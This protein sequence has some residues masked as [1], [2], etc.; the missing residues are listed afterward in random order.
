MGLAP[1]GRCNAHIIQR[2]EIIKA[3]IS[4]FM[5]FR[6]QAALFGKD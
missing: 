6:E 2:A 5:K 1:S 3:P 4:M